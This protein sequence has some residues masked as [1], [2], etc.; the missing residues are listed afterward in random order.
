M[1]FS[2]KH[3][4]LFRFVLYR[5]SARALLHTHITRADGS[6]R[7]PLARSHLLHLTEAGKR[8]NERASKAVFGPPQRPSPPPPPLAAVVVCWLSNGDSAAFGGGG[9]RRRRRGLSLLRRLRSPPLARFLLPSPSFPALLPSNG[10]RAASWNWWRLGEGLGENSLHLRS[11][12]VEPPTKPARRRRRRSLF[13]R[14]W[15]RWQ[16]PLKATRRRKRGPT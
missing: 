9:R 15:W 10:S 1:L 11:S 16:R 12:P 13:Q 6:R 8:A 14:A 4:W 2:L 7:P 3:L 5:A